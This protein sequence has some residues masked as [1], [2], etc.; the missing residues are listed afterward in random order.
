MFTIIVKKKSILSDTLYDLIFLS[1]IYS[2]P[3]ISHLSGIPFYLIEPMRIV[4]FFSFFMTSKLNSYFLAITIPLFSFIVSGH[5]LLLKS[6]LISIELL[7]NI[8]LFFLINQRLGAIVT[9]SIISIIIS[10]AIYYLF[11]S[12]FIFYL[13]FKG[14]VISTPL[15]LQL[16]PII[17]ITAFTFLFN[18]KFKVY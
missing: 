6:I 14:P 11:K 16:I 5:P 12:L 1:I 13:I 15:L 2:I 3:I 18:K 9:A 7:I 4:L 8:K 17:L 10:K